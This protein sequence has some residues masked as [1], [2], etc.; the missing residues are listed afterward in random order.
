MQRGRW[1]KVPSRKWASQGVLALGV[2]LKVSLFWASQLPLCHN[3]LDQG[4]GVWSQR[5]L[6][7]RNLFR[8]LVP[9]SCCHFFF[10]GNGQPSE[11][12]SWSG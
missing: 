8:P 10:S 5:T 6:S 12:L 2:W 11:T 1:E 3:P 7:F 4:K 9:S